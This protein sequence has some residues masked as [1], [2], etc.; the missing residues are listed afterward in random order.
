MSSKIPDPL[1]GVKDAAQFMG[2]SEQTMRNLA[3]KGAIPSTIDANG[4]RKFKFT[5]LMKSK[6]AAEKAAKDAAKERRKRMDL[7]QAQEVRR[8]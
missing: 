5:D 4:Y 8:G 7:L 3:D 2:K 6:M 1:V